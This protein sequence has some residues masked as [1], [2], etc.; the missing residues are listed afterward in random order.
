MPVD[1]FVHLHVHTEYSMLD[2]A[3][4]M[5]ALFA[6]AQ[7]L[8][9]P[10]V[11]MTDHGNMFGA[12]EFYQQAKK[13]G[14]KPIIGIE[15]YVAPTSRFHKKP[16]FWGEAK[17]RSTDE[18]GEGG[19]VSGAG[20]YTHMTML[21]R[22]ATGLRNLFTLSSLAS[23]E[24]QYRKP[25]MDR[26]LLAEHG[27]G[28]IAT[29]GC[30]SGEVQT[31]LRLGQY[32]EALQAAS[33]Y[34]DIFGAENFFVELMDHGL[35]I[36]RA[37]RENLLNISRELALEPLA[38]NDS[39]YVTVD[40]A[41][42]HGALLC[43]QSGKTLNDESRFKLDGDGYYLKSAEEMREYWDTEVPGAA[44]NTLRVTEMIESYDDVW[45]FQDRMP[46]VTVEGGTSERDQLQSEIDEYLPTRYPD[47]ASQEVL[48]RVK[49]EIDVLDTKGYCAYFLVVGDVT[50]WA[51]SQGIHVGPGRGSAAGSLLAYI[52]HITDLDPLEHGL[53]FE[54]FLNPERDSPPDI[55]LD[56]DD[57]RRD[58]VLQ[59]AIDKYGRG[60]V[61]QVITFGK[62]KTKAA[63]KDAARVH[64]GQ[65]GFAIADKI[66]KAL[67][68]PV[69]AKD[70]PLSGIVDPEHERY[71]EATE[72]RSLI[73]TDPSVS[74]IFDTARGL[75]GLIRNAGVH[76]CAVILSSQDLL[77][78]VPLWQR[79]D[80][81]VIT[82]WD[83]PS[84][85][86]IGLLKMDFLGLSN[87]TILGDALESV[88]ANHDLE[89]DLSTLGLDDRATYELLSRGESLGVFQL[90]GGGM[91]ELLKRMQPTEFGDVVAANALY[92]PG[93]MEVNAHLDYAD[94][95][96]GRKPVEPIHPELAEP[97]SD[98]LAETYGLIVY[99]E[100]IMA[101]AQKVAG[102]TLGQ[103]DILRRAMGKKKKEVLDE[104]FGRFQAGMR[105]QGY[106]DEAIDKLWSTVLP[107]AGYAFNKSHAAG[108]A[109]VAYWTAYLK[110]NYPAEY[111][112]ALLTSN[113]DNKDKMAVYLGECRRMGVKV[114]S[115]D[116]NDSGLMFTAVGSDVRFGL[117][118]IRNVGTNVVN[119]IATMRD[120]QGRYTSFTDFLDKSETVVC[121]KR[122]IESLI[123]AGA[124]DSLG[125][126]RMSLT[127]HHEAAVD[128]V[129]GLKR[130][131]A[132]GQFDLFGAD[133]GA[134]GAE[135]SSP[136]AHL[137]FTPEEWP[138]KQLLSYEREML[139]LYVSAHPLDGAERLLAPYQDTGIAALVSGDRESSKDGKEQQCK[140]A[141]MISGI[142]RR[143]NKN[144]HPW[145]IV[146]LEDLDAGVEVLFFPKSYEVFA[147]CLVEDTAIAVKGRINERE[148]TVSVFASDALP[149]DISAAETDPGTSPAFVIKV[150]A[151]RVDRSLVTELKRTLQAHSG[152]VPV[153]VKLQGPRGVTRLALSSDFFVATDNGLQGELKGLLG[154]GCFEPTG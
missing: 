104:E 60:K 1:P 28:I 76:A 51:K 119:S 13:T 29:T 102:Y 53:I 52:L 106:S 12:D 127:Q 136:L 61:A 101:I 92:R 88:R 15:A 95:K 44:D 36:E 113:G 152:D 151:N 135:N 105:E 31:R 42:S 146:T 107:F 81:S 153:H 63:I 72:V 140:I 86:A 22:N 103:A 122:V 87:L 50:R 8:G 24:G 68:P 25:R 49:T 98:I 147:D 94:R 138:R 17:Q 20:A 54:R 132:L 64:H 55:D 109:L 16:V 84:C 118:A 149:I 116:V 97:L 47:G 65:P 9:M 27:E 120:E 59:Y 124:F 26:D 40:Q 142:Q 148:G 7:R 71:A 123:K 46:R 128:A 39:H 83:Y 139:G 154:A 62:I 5:G 131:Q 93:P 141:G 108:Y 73:E 129:V 144:G 66:S 45:S 125:H 115:P 38:T 89:I 43:V 3:A 35:P 67:P 75:E 58:E 30:P 32:R 96:N 134:E 18:F 41:G 78:A 112:A 2:G 145:A 85:E 137:Q 21:A 111:M 56:F 121:N 19:D 33:D 57:R 14:I 91:R 150:P 70:I 143:I 79:D 130:Q 117:S 11:G 37:V 6:E 90:E 48:D 4:K 133:S 110:A 77:G 100:Q 114:L 99:Q 82:G 10:A 80:G 126:T 74:Q 34:K 69:A 23:M